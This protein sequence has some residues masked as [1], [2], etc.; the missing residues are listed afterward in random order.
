V[1][2]FLMK[3]ITLASAALVMAAVPVA[4]ALA[5]YGGSAPQTMPQPQQ[6]SQQS[7]QPLPSLNPGQGNRQ[8]NLTR[9]EQT[10]MIPLF[11]AVN[12]SDWV[13]AQ[14]ALPAAQA[15]AQSPDAKYA[16]GQS[17][18]RIGIGTNN[19]QVQ[20]QAVDAMIDSGGAHADELPRLLGFQI[21]FAIGQH[22]YDKAEQGLARLAQ[23]N[24]NDP[25]LSLRRAAIRISRNDFPGALQ[26]YQQAIQ[27]QQGAN[28]TVS[29]DLR[30]RALAAAYQGHLG[31][32]SIALSRELVAA[33]PNPTNWRDALLIYRQF[34][35]PDASLLLD[36]R[37][38]QR[39][40]HALNGE[41]DYVGLADALSRAGLPGEA[42]AVLDEAVSRGG[43]QASSSNI[44][45]LL[46]AVNGQVAQDRASLPGLR[47]QAMAAPNGR[48]A[49]AT[50]DAFYGYGDFAEAANLYRVA[51]QKGG[52]DPNLINLRLGAALAQAGQRAEAEAALHAVS[53][54]RAA[55]AGY[56]LL[57]LQ[58]PPQ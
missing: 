45:P 40:A 54:P 44:A 14:A 13:A 50:A 20:A 49:R 1:E 47:T 32:Q 34:G 5:Q 39:A 38:L 56:W 10:A 3:T 18:L 9:A 6:Q 30:K 29:E 16:L 57:L 25:E 58:H 35:Q 11:Q 31:P 42:K 28:Q 15:G 7:Q 27:A 52:E 48:Q 21:D 4:P 46:A 8:Y 12:R 24:P 17:L 53:G 55:L 2:T 37:R 51:L 41:A 43:L 22:N 36:L 26:L 23:L 33:Y 19:A